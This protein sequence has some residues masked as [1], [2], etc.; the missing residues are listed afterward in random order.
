MPLPSGS[1]AEKVERSPPMKTDLTSEVIWESSV[2]VATDKLFVGKIPEIYDRPPQD[3]GLF[4]T[5]A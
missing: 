5:R 1:V 3:F 2:M 4:L